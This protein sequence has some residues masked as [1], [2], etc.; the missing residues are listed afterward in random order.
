[1]ADTNQE[2]VYLP[3]NLNYL[4]SVFRGRPDAVL[5][6]GATHLMT[7]NN[8]VSRRIPSLGERIIYLGNVEELTRITRSDRYLELGACVT[9]QQ[10]LGIGGEIVPPALMQFLGNISSPGVRN[11][12]TIGGN[13][14]AGK[15]YLNC[16]P[17]LGLLEARIEVRKAG[18]SHWSTLPR[19]IDQDGTIR[20]SEGELITRIRIALDTCSFQIFRRMGNGRLSFCGMAEPQKE[21]LADLKFAFGIPGY[22]SIRNRDLE[23]ELIGRRLPLPEKEFHSSLEQLTATF[24]ALPIPVNDFIMET[25]RR[26]LTWF[27]RQ[28]PARSEENA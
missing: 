3:T 24:E 15:D 17:V 19:L 13:L 4:L 16:I 20:L 5:V 6:A 11:L 18:S 7:R 14:F 2:L 23:A 21:A 10:I 26:I 25:A 28:L 12:A 22:P 1:M 9:Q 27:F 8:T